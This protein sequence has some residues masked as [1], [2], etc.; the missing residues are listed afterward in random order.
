MPLK[1][2]KWEKFEVSQSKKLKSAKWFPC[3]IQHDGK[4]FRRLAKHKN[5]TEIFGA[6]ILLCQIAMKSE[7]RGVLA[8]EDGGLSYEDFELMTGHSA[9]VFEKAVSVLK[10]KEIGF[11]E[12]EIDSQ[13]TDSRPAVDSSGGRVETEENRIEENRKEQNRIRDILFG[14]FWDVYPR[15]R[16][17]IV[18]KKKSKELF[19]RMDF[20]DLKTII[21]NAINYGINNEF[22][23]DPERFLKDDF[24]KDWETPQLPEQPKQGYLTPSEKQDIER[25]KLKGIYNESM[26]PRIGQPPSL[27]QI[28]SDPAIRSE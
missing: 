20:E 14:D 10:S 23:K 12:G 13:S 11:I 8:D 18:G 2:R 15:R 21:V 6:F 16:G 17:K 24:W 9:A 4:K 5:G 26:E 1:I 27:D 3:P 7:P 19:A 25:D 22:P 28:G